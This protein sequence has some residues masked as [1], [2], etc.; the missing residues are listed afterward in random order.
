MDWLSAFVAR[1]GGAALF[2]F[3]FVEMIGA[4]FPAFAVFVLAGRSRPPARY[5]SRRRWRERSWGRSPRIL[6][7]MGRDGG[8]AG[9]F[10]PRCAG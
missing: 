4:P 8:A 9:R 7:G 1:F 5:P 6:S 10:C 3:A 2:L